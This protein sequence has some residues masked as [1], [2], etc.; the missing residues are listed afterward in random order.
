M[1]AETRTGGTA[2][3]RDGAKSGLRK[4]WHTF[5]GDSRYRDLSLSFFTYVMILLVVGLVMMS[6]AS[7]AWAYFDFGDG[8]HYAVSQGRNA[9][10]GFVLML[11]FMNMDYHNFKMIKLKGQNGINVAAILY[12]SVALLL[13]AVLIWGGDEGGSM[14]AK[15]W[16]MIGPVNFQPSEVAKFALIIFQ[17]NASQ[18]IV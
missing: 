4:L 13:V 3:N 6:S 8:L 18:T 10:I 12:V 9:I 16:I 5:N 15:R 17:N 1:A 2:E 11:F 14:G 7:Y